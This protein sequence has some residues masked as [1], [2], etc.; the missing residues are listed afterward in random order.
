MFFCPNENQT[1]FVVA[2]PD[3]G[4]H[5]NLAKKKEMDFDEILHTTNIKNV[6]YDSDDENFILLA[7]RYDEKLGFF[8]VKF[9]ERDPSKFKFLIKWKNKLEI[10]DTSM[11]VLRNTKSGLKELIV[12]C[13]T[14]YIN[15]YNVVA[16]DISV[17]DEQLMIFRHESF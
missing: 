17:E 2:S 11:Y 13:K 6:I 3:E 1:I 15:V 8:V 14:I 7:N 16:L 4:V 5:V 10:G 12:C 9:D